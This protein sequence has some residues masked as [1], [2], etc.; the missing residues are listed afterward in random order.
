MKTAK[1][2]KNGLIKFYDSNGKRIEEHP[3][4]FFYGSQQINQLI[5]DGWSVTFSD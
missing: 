5:A 3:I 1:I 4:G 2:L